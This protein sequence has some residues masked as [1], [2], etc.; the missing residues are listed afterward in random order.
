MPSM[1]HVTE[2]HL[3]LQKVRGFLCKHLSAFE[4]FLVKHSEEIIT[5]LHEGGMQGASEYLSNTVIYSSQFRTNNCW[6]LLNFAFK[7][8]A[9][10]FFGIHAASR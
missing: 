8:M 3:W 6:C 2:I 7:R 5:F 9:Q 4:L 1:T 10:F